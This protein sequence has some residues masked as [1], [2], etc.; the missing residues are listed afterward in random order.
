MRTYYLLFAIL[1]GAASA[2]STTKTGTPPASSQ[3]EEE[4]TVDPLERGRELTAEFYAGETDSL[5]S[6]MSEQMRA[7]FQNK[8]NLV[9][10]R[11]Q[12]EEQLGDETEVLNEEVAPA[13]PYQVYVRTASFEKG[14]GP[15][16]VQWTIEADGTVAGFFIR[17]AQAQ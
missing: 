1:L 10:F 14:E 17:P 16:V 12:V 5:W 15:V 13:P 9:A 3:S 2:C 8:E 4:S 11:Q 6:Q 7:A